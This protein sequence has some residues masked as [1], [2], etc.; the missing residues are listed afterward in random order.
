MTKRAAKTLGD[1]FLETANRTK[2]SPELLRE[3]MQMHTT[4]KPP[5]ESK[6]PDGFEPRML[7]FDVYG[8]LVNTPPANL[9]AFQAILADAGRLDLNPKEF[10]SFWEQR[11]IAMLRSR[12]PASQ[13]H[14]NQRRHHGGRGSGTSGTLAAWRRVNSPAS[15]SCTR[16]RSS[17]SASRR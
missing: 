11:N 6:L 10:Y 13:H 12:A 8:T 5:T 14:P 15:R 7:S 16:R 9:G 3:V 4:P 17:A 2:V 1:R